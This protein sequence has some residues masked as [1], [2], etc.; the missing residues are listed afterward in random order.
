MIDELKFLGLTENEIKI[1]LSLL[2]NTRSSGSQI[3]RLTGIANSRVYS[4]LDNLINLGLVSFET[5]TKGKIFSS[6]DP[7]VIQ[8]IFKEHMEKIE[9][10][11]PGLRKMQRKTKNETKSAIY[12]GFNGFKTAL[13]RFANECPAGETIYILGF[14]NQA[15]KSE[16]LR[17]ILSNAN[18][19]SIKKKHKFKM[20]LDNK[21]NI[22][23]KDR[24]LEGLS[25]IKFMNKGFRSPAAIDIFG[26]S[27]YIFLWDENP[28]AFVIKNKNIAEGF[29][30]Y[31]NFLW[32]IAHI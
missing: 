6:A 26:E 13:N 7:E 17:Y 32:E 19:I 30:N 16:K 5:T 15:Y 20:I 4:S 9:N 25:Q 12:E 24:K 27:V 14:S 21:E 28:H 1:Y 3:R 31:F 18:K 11:I 29:K 10:I 8:D 22:F 2:K 23:Y